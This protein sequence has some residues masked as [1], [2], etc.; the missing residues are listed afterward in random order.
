MKRILYVATALVLVT[1]MAV[2]ASC[3]SSGGSGGAGNAGLPMGA[4][5]GSCNMSADFMC[6]EYHGNGA[7]SQSS[8]AQLMTD[9]CAG[10][11]GTWNL[12]G[13]CTTVGALGFCSS[14]CADEPGCV[15]ATADAG[16]TQVGWNTYIY[17][18]TAAL[19]EKA[20]CTTPSKWVD[21][22]ADAGNLG[23]LDAGLPDAGL[24]GNVT[25]S[26]DTTDGSSHSCVTYTTSAT[27]LG[28]VESGCNGTHD[29]WSSGPCTTTGRL[30][31][32]TATLSGVATVLCY[33]DAG[34][35]SSEETACGYLSGTWSAN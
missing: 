18:A 9:N 10:R 19:G 25:G 3:G 12:A 8:T 14:L 33:Y 28:Y 23:L 6:E 35:L 11:S 13:A 5:I 17:D 24:S 27:M 20:D 21:L 34:D 29:T 26:C 22:V 1:G 15:T 7:V 16:V 32:C 31:H 2:A 30:G 4:L